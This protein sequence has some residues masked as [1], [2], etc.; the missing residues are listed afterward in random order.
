[1]IQIIVAVVLIKADFAT[2]WDKIFEIA[3][4]ATL[5]R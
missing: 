1:M 5:N 2:E 4:V 3:G